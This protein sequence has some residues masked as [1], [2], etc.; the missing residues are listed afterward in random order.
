MCYQDVSEPH[1]GGG[2]GPGTVVTTLSVPRKL[3]QTWG[4]IVGAVAGSSRRS[5]WADGALLACLTAGLRPITAPGVVSGAFREGV[6]LSGLITS[7]IA[8]AIFAAILML[9]KKFIM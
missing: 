3:L 8:A 1:P 9:V 6:C 4:V 7:I 5:D 2:G